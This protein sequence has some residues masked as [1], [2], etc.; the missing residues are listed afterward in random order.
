MEQ[1]IEPGQKWAEKF[2]TSI[3]LVYDYD[4]RTEEVFCINKYKPD[5]HWVELEDQFRADHELIAEDE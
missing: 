2:G 5:E 1:R 3:F 4:S